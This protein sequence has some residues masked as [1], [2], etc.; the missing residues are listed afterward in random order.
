VSSIDFFKGTGVGNEE[1]L[2]EMEASKTPSV[3][4]IERS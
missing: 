3:P 1:R 2:V 4:F